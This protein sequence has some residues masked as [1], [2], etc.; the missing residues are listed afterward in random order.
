MC[1]GEPWWPGTV[2]LTFDGQGRGRRRGWPYEAGQMACLRRAVGRRGS[3]VSESCAARSFHTRPPCGE[4]RTVCSRATDCV[5]CVE[6]K[7]GPVSITGPVLFFGQ[8]CQRQYRTRNE[9]LVQRQLRDRTGFLRH[10]FRCWSRCSRPRLG[11][12]PKQHLQSTSTD[13][14]RGPPSDC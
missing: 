6:Q 14:H 3:P 10:R 8:L 4:L 1:S 9:V 2:R 7:T 5:A 11:R 13:N 12:E